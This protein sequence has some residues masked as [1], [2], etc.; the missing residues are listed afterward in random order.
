MPSGS[1]SADV[2]RDPPNR[3]TGPQRRAATAEEAFQAGLASLDAVS[4]EDEVR[5]R[6]HTPQSVPAKLR[7]TVRAA[8]RAGLAAARASPQEELRGWKLHAGP[9]HAP[10]LGAVPC[11]HRPRKARAQLGSLCAGAVATVAPPSHTSCPHLGE[12][13]AAP[14]RPRGLTSVASTASC[15]PCHRGSPLQTTSMRVLHGHIQVYIS[16]AHTHSWPHVRQPSRRVRAQGRWRAR[17]GRRRWHT[18]LGDHQAHQVDGGKRRPAVQ[19]GATGAA[20]E[21][22]EHGSAYWGV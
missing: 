19:V 7:G 9:A 16:Q 22:G 8:L 2:Q 14:S 13:S 5:E 17:Q 6:V 15:S 1:A 18:P 4:L 21:G 20:G 10:A 12:L 11:T 3:P